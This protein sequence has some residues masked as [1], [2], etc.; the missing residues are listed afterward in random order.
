M[1]GMSC[2][3]HISS[4]RVLGNVL[5]LWTASTFKSAELPTLIFCLR[6]TEIPPHLVGPLYRYVVRRFLK[7][8]ILKKRQSLAVSPTSSPRYVR[9]SSASNALLHEPS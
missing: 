6:L 1:A 5:S 9:F 7:E 2:Q 8:L 4:M 3:R